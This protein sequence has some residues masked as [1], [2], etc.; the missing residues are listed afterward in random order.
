MK[1]LNLNKLLS[2][3]SL[4][5][6][7]MNSVLGNTPELIP[8]QFVD[9]HLKNYSEEE[10]RLID[11]ELNNI[12]QLCFRGQKPSVN[13][14]I[15]VATAGGPGASK[16]TILETYLQEN[17]EFVYA[18]PDQRALKFMINT[19]LQSLTNYQIS[20]TP[21]YRLLLNSAY[22][23]WR[24]GSNYIA[25]KILNN[26]YTQNYNI[27]HGTTSTAKEISGLYERLKERKYKIILLLCG[28]T[29]QNRINAL[30]TR[31]ETQGFVQS[32]DEDTINKGKAF[33]ERLPVYFQYADEIQIYWTQDFKQ[34][35]IKAATFDRVKGL[36]ILDQK[37]F[38]S[39]VKQ[40]ELA[41]SEKKELVPF[42]SIVPIL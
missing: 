34:G 12:S 17:S 39:F 16:S 32:S 38:D 11:D 25:C 2:I 4:S 35:N 42:K 26:A 40:Y 6:I 20:K 18:D 1:L 3:I 5:I 41:R 9:G 31:A 8:G 30:R 13:Q 10:R 19:Y 15:Y 22:E 24:A 27:A 33:W 7:L 21:S 29:D 23:K 37:A 36:K 14:L 28:S